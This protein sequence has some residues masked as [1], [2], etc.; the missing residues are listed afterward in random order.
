MSGIAT[1]QWD[2][3][4]VEELY[5]LAIAGAGSNHKTCVG[6]TPPQSFV[7]FAKSII[8]DELGY[9]VDHWRYWASSLS[10][11][12]AKAQVRAI[13]GWQLM[14][15]HTHGWDGR[16]LV[17][18]LNEVEGGG[19]LAVLDQDVETEL[20]CWE[21]TPGM[22]AVMADH[23]VHGVKAIQGD[24]NRVTMIAGAYPYPVGSTKCRCENQDWVRVVN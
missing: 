10:P 6:F 12:D 11:L 13:D 21:P 7:D 16:T 3:C 1:F 14:F 22:A 18:Y 15:P 2:D 9:E 5:P 17:L 19:E 20:A 23:A 24:T 8:E 4:P